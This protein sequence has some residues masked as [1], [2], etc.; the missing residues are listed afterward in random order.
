MTCEVCGN[1]YHK[2]LSQNNEGT[3]LFTKC[4]FCGNLNEH[5]PTKKDRRNYRGHKKI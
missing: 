3:K 4:P 1:D 2:K 5:K